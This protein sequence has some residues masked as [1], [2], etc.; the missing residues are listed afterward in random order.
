MVKKYEKKKRTKLTEFEIEE[1]VSCIIPNIWRK[2]S[3]ITRIP[4]VIIDK[5]CGTQPL[6]TL[7]SEFGV[8]KGKFNASNL[9]RYPGS[10]IRCNP[11]KKIS[12]R[13][14]AYQLLPGEPV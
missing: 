5:F 10:I 1:H 7:M 6:Y 12:L 8:L 13:T 2:K 9:I 11:E 3:N 14:A 4:C